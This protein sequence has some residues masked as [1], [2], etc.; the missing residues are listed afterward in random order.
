MAQVIIFR[1]SDKQCSSRRSPIGWQ[2]VAG[3][4]RA[5]GNMTK[6]L[7]QTGAARVARAA[8]QKLG[9][10]FD[11]ANFLGDSRGNPLVQ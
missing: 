5:I 7:R 1:K 3:I 11:D 10:R 6:D 9:R 8:L 2:F 4:R